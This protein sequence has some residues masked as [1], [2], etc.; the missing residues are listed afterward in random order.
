VEYSFDGEREGVIWAPAA[1]WEAPAPTP[2]LP[3]AVSIA[4]PASGAAFE[5][6]ATVAFEGTA[7]DPEEG[8]L[9]S[10]IVWNSNIDGQIG[11]GGTLSRTLSVGNHT[12]TASVTDAGDNFASSSM[13]IT[14]GSPSEVTTVQISS[15]VYGEAGSTLVV[16]V[17]LSDEFGNPVQGAQV[18]AELIEWFYTLMNWPFSGTTN[19][20]G[21][22]QFQLINAPIGC[23]LTDVGSITAPGLTWVG[24]TPTN[25]YCK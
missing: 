1:V 18:S 17:G 14:V 24:G 9:S 8:D 7:L 6:G 19:S 10:S 25:Y 15:I 5:A 20:Q 23:Y 22:V 12:I 13:S 21:R 4:S 2:D 11:T 3:P 16:T